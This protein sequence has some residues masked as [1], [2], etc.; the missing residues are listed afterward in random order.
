MV[1]LN[2]SNHPSEKWCKEQRAAAEKFGKGIEIVDLPFPPVDPC[3][4]EEELNE[5]VDRYYAAV[6]SYEKPVVMLQ[7][8]Y[9]F[10]YRL[11][12]RLKKENI[13]VVASCSVRKSTEFI[14]ENGKT[15]RKS[16]F[17][18]AAFREY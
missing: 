7:G 1:F 11:L 17:E 12:C 9:R 13:T 18:F 4:T 3:C 16:F 14:D 8:E 15:V 5:L 10:T 2:I 6:M